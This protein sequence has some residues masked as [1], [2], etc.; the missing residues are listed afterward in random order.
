MRPQLFSIAVL[1]AANTFSQNLHPEDVDEPYECAAT[2]CSRRANE[3]EPLGFSFVETRADVCF[4]KRYDLLV[5]VS[6]EYL[7]GEEEILDVASLI[8]WRTH[9]GPRLRMELFAGP[10]YQEKMS[11][12][13]DSQGVPTEGSDILEKSSALRLRARLIFNSRYWAEYQLTEYGLHDRTHAEAGVK[14]GRRKVPRI[15]AAYDSLYKGAVGARLHL[16]VGKFTVEPGVA[17]TATRFDTERIGVLASFAA[18]IT[19]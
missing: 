11:F 16:M 4:V 19:I 1:L 10:A 15:Y 8:G 17:I 9:L 5:R 18:S 14:I 2:L 12:A 13:E 6:S 7:F 3:S